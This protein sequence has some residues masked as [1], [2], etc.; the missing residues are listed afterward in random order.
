[1]FVLNL[2]LILFM[3][4]LCPCTV[5]RTKRAELARKLILIC[6]I[7][8][9]VTGRLPLS[10]TDSERPGDVKFTLTMSIVSMWSIRVA[11]GY[12]LSVICGLGVAGIWYALLADGVVRMVFSGWRCS[13]TGGPATMCW[14]SERQRKR[15]VDVRRV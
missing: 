2:I 11:L 9:M 3:D 7:G 6:S 4:R 8:T 13:R 10:A 1:M 14:N 15:G 5:W 12:V